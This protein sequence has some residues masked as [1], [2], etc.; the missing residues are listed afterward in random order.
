MASDISTLPVAL[1]N[2]RKINSA[3]RGLSAIVVDVLSFARQIEPSVMELDAR[4][5]LQR[6]A[7][8]HLPATEA[9]GVEV[10]IHA[11]TATLHADADLLH[12]ALLNLARNAVDAM[13]D[14]ERPRRLTLTA[15]GQRLTVADTG[16][17][18]D[19]A[20][21]DR[22]FNPFF[23]TRN[24]GTGL[25]LAIVHRIVDAHGGTISVRNDAAGGGAIFTL[26]LPKPTTKSGSGNP[27]SG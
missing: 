7:D 19:A 6:V 17:G 14:R 1:D 21:V 11:E 12:Q 5:T 20:A 16:P 15:R 3:V 22:L 4:A 13:A 2:T 10:V 9:A 26:T 27:E 18:I 8:A 24:T 25:G 23:T